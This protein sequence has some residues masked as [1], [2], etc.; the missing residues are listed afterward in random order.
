MY[1]HSRRRGNACLFVFSLL[2]FGALAGCDGDD[3]EQGPAGE[4]G[5]PGTTIPVSN[6]QSDLTLTIT[7]ASLGD[8]STV[9]FTLIDESGLPYVGL[10]ASTLEVMLARLLPG[11]DG[12]ADSWQSYI[13]QTEEPSGSGA[14]TEE[15]IIAARDSGGSLEDHNDGSYSYTFGADVTHVTEPRAVEYDATL[16]HRVAIAVRSGT[17]PTVNNAVYTWQPSTGSTEPEDGRDMVAQ[18]SCNACHGDLSAHGG[19]R[20]D[21]KLCVTCHNPGS[22]EASSGQ[23]ID[24]MVMIHRIHAGAELP[25]VVAGTP[26]LIYGY[27]NSVH[28]YSEVEFPKDLRN[29]TGCHNPDDSSTPQAAHFINK[30][31]LQAC[32]SC[33]DDVDFAAGAAGGHP[34]GVVTDNTQCTVCHAENRVAGSV[35]ESHQIPGKL[36]AARFQYNIL[37]IDDTGQG[38]YPS[39][40]FS[41][42][43]PEDG[44]APYDILADAPFT[45]GGNSSLSIDIAW[46]TAD[47]GNVGSGD[48]PGGPVAISAL[49]AATSNGDGT[50]TVTSS[51]PV[52]YDVTGSGTVAIEGHPAGD[53]DGDGIYSDRI[54]VTGV[55]ENF[56]IT[57]TVPAARRSV[58]SLDKCQACHGVNDGLSFHGN[59]RTDNV[60][61]CTMCH[62]PNATDLAVRPDDPDASA[63]GVNT[64]AVD[65]LEQR[66]IDFK[67][68]I[69]AI[70][71]AS[72]RSSN[73]V[74][75]GY[76]S[77]VNDFSGIGYPGVVAN[78]TQCHESS[79]YALPLQS[80]VLGTT[81]DTHA[82]RLAGDFSPPGAVEDLASYGRISPASAVCSSCHDDQAAVTHMQQNGGGFGIT[83]AEIGSSAA[84]TESCAVCHGSGSI[85]D[86]AVVHGLP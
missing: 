6:G 71:G 77:S 80:T 83:A 47:Y 56:A 32:G 14:G 79:S 23:S 20:R 50:F 26:Y 31:T 5:T 53:Y 22:V 41:V 65:G 11:T 33:H 35:P 85:A 24:F 21:V 54:P 72:V 69:H 40:S 45:A 62:T 10:P 16:T 82:T 75:Y 29:C 1:L 84:T 58:V 13:N 12:D 59:N 52:P 74:V 64:A 61:L 15:T 78:C 38:Q 51:V 55:T 27:G 9:D 37:S 7:G 73:F 17:L 19:A 4:P 68:M 44:N 66:P 36:W 8:S 49:S 34:G 25:S 2:L 28:D 43:N 86:V 46:S 60:Q 42:T 76:R 81:I 67:L 63:N 39:V 18:A 57:D 48:Y 70:H 30:P 3:G